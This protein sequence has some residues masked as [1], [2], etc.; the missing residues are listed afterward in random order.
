MAQM[1]GTIRQMAK[2]AGRDPQ[3]LQL[4]VRANLV[5]TEKPIEK[6]RFVFV[7]SLDQIREDIAA[8]E[9]I[10]ADELFLEVGFYARGQV[11]QRT[12]SSG[13]SSSGRC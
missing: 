9:K 11:W 12:G 4:I 3:E 13:G 10:G 5:I 8:S 7:G 2:D 6:D 1:F